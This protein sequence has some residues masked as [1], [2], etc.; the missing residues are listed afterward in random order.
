ML[1]MGVWSAIYRVRD[2]DINQG[3]SI[4]LIGED[5]KVLPLH[6]PVKIREEVYG[7]KNNAPL[8]EWSKRYVKKHYGIKDDYFISDYHS[9]DVSIDIE[10]IMKLVETINRVLKNPKLGKKLYPYPSW[11]SGRLCYIDGESASHLDDRRY[12]DGYLQTIYYTAYY[13]QKIIDEHDQ[14]EYVCGY[15]YNAG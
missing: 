6:N 1:Y 4:R 12:N 9:E 3:C 15:V 5:G 14:L 7:S 10:D 13:L 11:E 8:H 2:I